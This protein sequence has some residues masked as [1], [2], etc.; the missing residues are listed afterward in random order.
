MNTNTQEHQ[1]I[2]AVRKVGGYA[3]LRQINEIVDFSLWK[4]KTP[5]ASVRRIVQQSNHFFKIRPGLWAL[6]ES[7]EHILRILDLKPG[8]RNSE[9]Q[10]SHGY[11]QGL[12]VEIG[13]YDNGF[14]KISNEKAILPFEDGRIF[15]VEEKVGQVRYNLI[16]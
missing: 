4:T 3:T 8:N 9:E 7:R 13:K 15:F 10:F 5:E 16:S 1:V 2:E 6:Q 12:L 14:H 11:Y